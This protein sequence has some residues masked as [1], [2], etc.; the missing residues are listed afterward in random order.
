MET[1]HTAYRQFR[2]AFGFASTPNTDFGCITPNK[3]NI[4]SHW[5]ESVW[6]STHSISPN[7]VSIWVCINL[8][9]WSVFGIPSILHDLVYS[10][11]SELRSKLTGF[12][13]E[14]GLTRIETKR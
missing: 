7:Y 6:N 13:I 2:S 5:F 11:S 8:K 10:D 4:C 9:Y 3:F 14:V 12:E 1:Q